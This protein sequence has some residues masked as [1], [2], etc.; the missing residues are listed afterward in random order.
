MGSLVE[1]GHLLVM[2]QGAS[3]GVTVNNYCVECLEAFY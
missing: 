3:R 2:K 1:V